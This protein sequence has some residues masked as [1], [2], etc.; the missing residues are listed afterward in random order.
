MVNFVSAQANVATEELSTNLPASIIS[1]FVFFIAI[2]ATVVLKWG[3]IGVGSAVLLTRLVDFL[4]RFFPTMKRVLSWETTHVQPAGLRGRMIAFSWQSVASMI[5]AMIVW[6]RS[7][8]FLL[9]HLNADIRQIAY[10]SVAFSM[11]ERLLIG[12]AV[13]GSAAGATIFAQYGRDKTK[14]PS[15]VASG[16]AP[17]IRQTVRGRNDGCDAGPNSVHA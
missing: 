10:Y 9:K 12:S 17:P 6:D 11:A 13:F 14:L 16:V 5:V 15:I 7:E 4:V 1:I 3:V 8:F 2:L